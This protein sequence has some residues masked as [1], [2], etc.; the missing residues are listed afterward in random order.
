MRNLYLKSEKASISLYVLVSML[1]FL[2]I[3]LGLYFQ[4]SS[5][6][7]IQNN[8][9]EKIRKEYEKDIENMDTIYE[10]LKDGN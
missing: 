6:T 7:Q 9:I 2:I 5:K 10:N 1:F 8:Q 4:V 3:I